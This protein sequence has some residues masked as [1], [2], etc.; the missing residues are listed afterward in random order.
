M[1][2]ARGDDKI[3]ALEPLVTASSNLML[4][5]NAHRAK[6]ELFEGAVAFV[7]AGRVLAELGSKLLHNDYV[8]EGAQEILHSAACFLEA[9]DY[10]PGQEQLDRFESLPQLAALLHEDEYLR[11]EHTRINKWSGEIRKKFEVVLREMRE[12]MKGPEGAYRLKDRWLDAT[13]RGMPGVI[14]FHAAAA[15]KHSLMAEKRND[16]ARR[17]RG[18]EHLRWCVKLAPHD[19]RLRNLLVLEL[20]DAHSWRE[21]IL[22]SDEAVQRFSGDAYVH[23]FAGWSRFMYVFQGRGPKRS[24]SYAINYVREAIRLGDQM[25]E[26]HRSAAEWTLVG[27]LYLLKDREEADKL[28]NSTIQKY[29]DARSDIGLLMSQAPPAKRDKVFG[30]NAPRMIAR[31]LSSTLRA[32]SLYAGAA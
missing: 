22:E 5:A 2:Q 29:P 7:T 15:R 9:G 10:R 23:V 32:E 28:L 19:P 3:D 8:R 20:L 21:A 17:T 30:E 12:Q 4:A 16:E 25:T 6:G 31:L 24:L 13:L 18:I 26:E 27:C 14:Q 1:I 11:S